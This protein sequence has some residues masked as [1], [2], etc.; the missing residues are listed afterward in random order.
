MNFKR[1][2]PHNFGLNVKSDMNFSVARFL[3]I[4]LL[5]LAFVSITL[6]FV[7]LFICFIYFVRSKLFWLEVLMCWWVGVFFKDFCFKDVHPNDADTDGTDAV[8][9]LMHRLCWVLKQATS[10][11]LW[12]CEVDDNI[13]YRYSFSNS[14]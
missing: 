5:F 6:V 14:Q 1:K 7:R 12:S 4:L 11:A 9:M 10:A 3:F 8:L 2:I 13:Q